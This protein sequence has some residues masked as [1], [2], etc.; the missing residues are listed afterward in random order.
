MHTCNEIYKLETPVTE[1]QCKELMKSTGFGY[2]GG[3]DRAANL[4]L[5]VTSYSGDWKMKMQLCAAQLMNCD[6]LMLDEPTG[7]LN[8]ANIKW[9]EDRKL[10]T[11]KGVKA[12]TL[13]MFVEKYP[14]KKAYFGL[15]NETMKFAFPEPGPLEGVKSRS[16]VVLRMTSVDFQYPTKD[17]PTIVDVNLTVSQVSRVAVIGANGAGKSTA[18]KLL[19]GEQ[20]PTSGSIWKAAGLRLAYVAQHAFHHLEK[21][22]QETPT[23]YIMWR[24][25]GNHDKECIE[26]KQGVEEEAKLTQMARWRVVFAILG[27]SAVPEGSWRT[28][29]R[30]RRRTCSRSSSLTRLPTRSADKRLRGPC[31]LDGI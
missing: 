26:F 17:K 10:K 20:L 29:K 7:H 25:A 19:V 4:E 30:R 18:I 5:P 24:F 9:L 13:T 1:E 15:S 21:H 3:P 12:N 2:P 14:E 23:Q 6:V 16:K 11:F 8:V 31:S 27:S 28:W 22:M